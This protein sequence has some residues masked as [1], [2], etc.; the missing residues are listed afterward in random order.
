[1]K[2]G[3]NIKI[4]LFFKLSLVLLGLLGMIVFVVPY[5]I[6]ISA[7]T[8]TSSQSSIK[9]ETE[10]KITLSDELEG[11]V[12]TDVQYKDGVY[13]GKARSLEVSIGIKNG[14]IDS[15]DILSHR[16]QKGFYEEAFIKI[17]KKVVEKQ[18][19]DVDVVAGASNTSGRLISAIEDA[20]GK[21][22]I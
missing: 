3:K 9:T 22:K 6:S 19:G 14:I 1:M 17:P 7:D 4:R 2:S 20:L 15:V 16:E 5:L 10:S 18:S 8:V 13:K 21:A 12:D 11:K